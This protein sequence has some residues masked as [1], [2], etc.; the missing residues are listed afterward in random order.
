MSPEEI[1]RRYTQGE[2]VTRISQAAHRSTS[3]IY[4]IL[5]KHGV[6][7]H[8]PQKGVYYRTQRKTLA[9][10]INANAV[11]E[12]LRL[13]KLSSSASAAVTL[14]GAGATQ[15]AIARELGLSRQRIHQIVRK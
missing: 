5:R 11:L 10:D 1:V 6:T 15:S 9:L 4:R 13:S 14:Y 2:R 7:M 12:Q 3:G 8:G